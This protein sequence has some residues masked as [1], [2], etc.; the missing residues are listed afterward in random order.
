MSTTKKNNT[1]ETLNELRNM[2]KYYNLHKNDYVYTP[3]EMIAIIDKAI[4]DLTSPDNTYNSINTFNSEIRFGLCY[5]IKNSACTLFPD[6]N[7][8]C[9]NLHNLFLSFS[10]YKYVHD[11]PFGLFWFS[12]KIDNYAITKRLSLLIDIKTEVLHQYSE[13]AE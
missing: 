12:V 8:Y 4:T 6:K 11:S 1:D 7:Y 9:S 2:A 13:G 5:L 3:L 10:P